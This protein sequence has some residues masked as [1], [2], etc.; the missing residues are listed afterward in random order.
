MTEQL[1]TAHGNH[2]EEISIRYKNIWE[3]DRER[4]TNIPLQK[5][6]ANHKGWQ[7]EK[8]KEIRNYK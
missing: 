4:N 6:S 5:K 8:K 7:Q 3:R 1:S 2:K